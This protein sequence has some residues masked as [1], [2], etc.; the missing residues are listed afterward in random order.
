M[1][2]LFILIAATFFSASYG[3]TA[4]AGRLMEGGS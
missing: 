1:D 4:L 3:L 2:V